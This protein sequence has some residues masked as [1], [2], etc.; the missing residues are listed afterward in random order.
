MMLTPYAQK[1]IRRLDHLAEYL[2]IRR[3]AGEEGFYARFM[4]TLSR[5]TSREIC[6]TPAQLMG[7]TYSSYFASILG[8]TN[9][10]DGHPQEEMTPDFGWFRQLAHN[11]QTWINYWPELIV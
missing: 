7:R 5:L 11:N 3:N 8:I 6:N 2:L 4:G 9:P 1:E 10:S